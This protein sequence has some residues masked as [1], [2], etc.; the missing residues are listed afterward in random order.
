MVKITIDGQEADVPRGLTVVDAAKSVGIEIPIFCYYDKMK[1]VAACRMCLVEIEKMRGLVPACATYVAEGMVVHTNTPA[2]EAQQRN[3]LEFLLINHPLDC[4]V[5]DKGGECPLQDTTFKFGPGVSRYIEP[6]RHFVKPIQLSEYI[7]LDRERCIMCY[8]CVRFHSD[9]AQDYALGVIHRGADSEIG[10]A[11]GH[12]LDSP[13]QGNITELCPVGA[14]TS[15]YYRFT[16]RPWDIQQVPSVCT[17][18]SI[19][20]N[21]SFTIREDA[22]K[23]ILSRRNDPVDDGWLCDRGRY[24][25][26]PLNSGEKL[27]LPLMRKNGELV[28]VSWREALSAVAQRLGEI[29]KSEGGQAIGGVLA[30]TQPNEAAYVFQK[31]FRT[32]IGS[33]NVDY[34]Q[35]AQGDAD[36][37]LQE[38]FG[39]RAAMGSIQG[40]ETAKT[41]F[42]I[43]AN[44]LVEQPVLDLR[45][46]KAVGNGVSLITVQHERRK[47]DYLATQAV[48]C[49]PEHDVAVVRALLAAA[50]EDGASES[51]GFREHLS[52][53]RAEV[54]GQTVEQLAVSAGVDAEQLR[55][56][57][58]QLKAG[59]AVLMYSESWADGPAGAE[60]VR[61]LSFL[62]VAT[63][64][65][66]REGAGINRLPLA[67]NT[68]GVIDCGVHPALLPGHRRLD[69]VAARR[70]MSTLWEAD[71]PAHMGLS[72]AEM[73]KASADGRLRALV[74]GGVDPVGQWGDV[75]RESLMD[76]PYLVV[77][78]SFLTETAQGA[79][80]VLPLATY[81][82]IDGT[83]TNLE[84]RIQRL[85]PAISAAGEAL[86]GWQI[87]C[88]LANRMG[89]RFFYGSAAEVMLEIS[90]AVPI[91]AGVTYGRVGARGI[92]WPVA[93]RRH[94][95]TAYLYLPT[96][97]GVTSES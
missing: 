46:R 69:D 52:A 73:L 63:G 82:E 33:N 18:C 88:D 49:T 20:C 21:I 22:I 47:L 31:F 78:D 89:G 5:C 55:A 17:E 50:L 45:I 76:I 24:S 6:K 10:V 30:P 8:R 71:I 66:G 74:C 86:P 25:F 83:V 29:V 43:G 3:L 40:L 42:L 37:V 19:G 53:A 68:Q 93:D 91:Y 85:R 95:G 64:N 41:I 38:L 44:P 81:A 84:R 2:V 27:S 94:P 48:R 58:R 12:V 54:A 56:V 87:V 11:P 92:Q 23:R 32:I 75:A 67:A 34:R 36:R 4:P 70:E 28:T 14:L 16:A 35:P 9:I 80:V 26:A 13:F 39:Y 97:V 65:V 77:I 7:Y 62:A 90:Q 61:L 57:V 1:P 51:G 96:A 60:G 15:A 79:D 72:T 59:P